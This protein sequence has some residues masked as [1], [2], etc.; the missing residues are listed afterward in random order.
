MGSLQSDIRFAQGQAVEAALRPWAALL[1]NADTWIAEL[2]IPLQQVEHTLTAM[3]E[4]DEGFMSEAWLKR[5]DFTI[6]THPGG[7]IAL[8]G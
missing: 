1:T 7:F 8:A 4:S 6:K 5:H 3:G 2:W